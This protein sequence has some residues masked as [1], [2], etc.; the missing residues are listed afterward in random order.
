MSIGD[1]DK[2]RL[3][4]L[5]V[6]D[7]HGVTQQHLSM[8]LG[9]NP[10]TLAS[11]LSKG[12][13]PEPHVCLMLAGLAPVADRDYWIEAS[14]L[15]SEQLGYVAKGL[16]LTGAAPSTTLLQAIADLLENPRDNTERAFG[17]VVRYHAKHRAQK[18]GK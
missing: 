6:C 1:A 13:V 16:G 7:A 18:G 10:T 9:L 8:M 3:N 14:T 15:T 4:V 11:S 5:H 12:R 17:E 2:L